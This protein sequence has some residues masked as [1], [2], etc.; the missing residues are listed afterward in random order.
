MNTGQFRDPSAINSAPVLYQSSLYENQGLQPLAPNAANMAGRVWFGPTCEQ[1][2]FMY[3]NAY[4]HALQGFYQYS[5]PDMNA[6]SHKG[7]STGAAGLTGL[8]S[9]NTEPLC[10]NPEDRASSAE[11]PSSDAMEGAVGGACV[12]DKKGVSVLL[13]DDLTD[14]KLKM[15]SCHNQEPTQNGDM[16]EGKAVEDDTAMLS[17]DDVSTDLVAAWKKHEEKQGP[18]DLENTAEQKGASK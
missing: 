7:E 14:A 17:A 6:S 5:A 8:S 10:P 4:E 11:Q 9:D 18:H 1:H 16:R 2:S 12:A 3:P 15:D 13:A